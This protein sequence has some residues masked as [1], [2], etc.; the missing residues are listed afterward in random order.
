MLVGVLDRLTQPERLLISE[1]VDALYDVRDLVNMLRRVD[2][3]L[4]LVDRR[5]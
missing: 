4:P 5:D 3:V 2:E 1:L